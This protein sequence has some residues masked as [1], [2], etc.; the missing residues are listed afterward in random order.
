[1]KGN[2]RTPTPPNRSPRTPRH[3]PAPAGHPTTSPILTDQVA[4]LTATIALVREVTG[5]TL[6]TP[7]PSHLRK[8]LHAPAKRRRAPVTPLRIPRRHTLP[9]VVE[10][11][12]SHHPTVGQ[13]ELQRA[14]DNPSE[15]GD[16]DDRRRSETLPSRP[17]AA[18]DTPHLTTPHNPLDVKPQTTRTLERAIHRVQPECS[19]TAHGAGLLSQDAPAGQAQS[20]SRPGTRWARGSSLVAVQ[21]PHPPHP[22]VLSLRSLQSSV[23]IGHHPPLR[24]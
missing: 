5:N 15:P 16:L 9:A 6:Q 19:P 11:P 23:G 2:T 10:S 1:V 4:A 21:L 24:K 3:R 18:F 20:S 13:R 22:P 8:T 7:P 14:C 12:H 17:G